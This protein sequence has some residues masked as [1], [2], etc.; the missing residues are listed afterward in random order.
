ML[1]VAASLLL[2]M[3]KALLIGLPLFLSSFNHGLSSIVL[4]ALQLQLTAVV[5]TGQT[6]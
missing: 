1:A 3:T 2:N 6:G 4:V 5:A